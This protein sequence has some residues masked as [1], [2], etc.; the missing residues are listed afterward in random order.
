M[1]RNVIFQKISKH[2]AHMHNFDISICCKSSFFLFTKFLILHHFPVL[3]LPLCLPV[4][5]CREPVRPRSA[6]DPLCTPLCTPSSRDA[7]NSPGPGRPVP[8]S[9]FCVLPLCLP[10]VDSIQ[11]TL[12]PENLGGD[13]KGK[14]IRNYRTLTDIYSDTQR[15][16]TDIYCDIQSF[17]LNNTHI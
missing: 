6:E 16:L 12:A 13:T 2:S 5:L 7:W 4:V 14:Q 8:L 17:I 1:D 3:L 15:V 11:W 9:F 10:V